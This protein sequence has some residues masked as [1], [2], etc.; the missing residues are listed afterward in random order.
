MQKSVRD[1]GRIVAS[2]PLAKAGQL[3]VYAIDG[4]AYSSAQ[5]CG[6]KGL[7]RDVAAACAQ[8]DGAVARLHLQEGFAR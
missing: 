8:G 2:L 7:L 5:A 1:A 3:R 4:S 6:I